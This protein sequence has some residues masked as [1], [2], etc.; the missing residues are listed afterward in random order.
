MCEISWEI[1]NAVI[2][3]FI[4]SGQARRARDELPKLKTTRAAARYLSDLRNII[5]TMPRMQKDEKVD[6]FIEGLNFNIRVEVLKA[7]VETPDECAHVALNIDSE[8]WMDWKDG[9][10]FAFY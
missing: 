1:L 10:S 3:E 4:P 5:Q 6:I 7:Q 9:T 2:T 8:I